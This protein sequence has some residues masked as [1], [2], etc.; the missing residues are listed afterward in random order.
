MQ[1]KK[2]CDPG[3]CGMIGYI[4]AWQGNERNHV[5]N[6]RINSA[7]DSI[8]NFQKGRTGRNRLKKLFFISH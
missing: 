7:A 1:T 4:V 5:A 2:R 6:L 8:K 3:N